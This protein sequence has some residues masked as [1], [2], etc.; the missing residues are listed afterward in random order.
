MLKKTPAL[1]LCRGTV[2]DLSQRTFEDI[3]AFEYAV[4]ALD[5]HMW[6]MLRNYLPEKA[7][8]AQAQ[9]CI[10]GS[11]VGSHGVH[12]GPYLQSLIGALTTYVNCYKL[13]TLEQRGTY[14]QRHVGGAQILL[15]AHAVN[16]YCRPD[17]ALDP[18][19]NF[20]E[21]SLPRTQKIVE[22]DWFTAVYN[23]GKLG[24]NFGVFRGA[25]WNG[26][27]SAGNE[28]LARWWRVGGNQDT[29]FSCAGADALAISLLTKVRLQQREQLLVEL[30]VSEEQ[31]LRP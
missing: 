5:W 27:A 23:G 31:R 29:A 26:L 19:P 30:S 24:E 6:K 13:W 22:G 18:S 16:E 12:V 10:T 3:T 7:A 17:R 2:T 9:Q 21:A 1:T 28:P 25:L 8:Q 11:W 4:W 20:L 14:W 15:P